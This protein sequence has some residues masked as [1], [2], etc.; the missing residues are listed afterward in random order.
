M[1]KLFR[2]AETSRDGAPVSL[3][4]TA[5]DEDFDSV[6]DLIESSEPSDNDTRETRD[7]LRRRRAA[8]HH[9]AAERGYG[10]DDQPALASSTEPS[11][12]DS[13]DTV[14][15][16]PTKR[17]KTKAARKKARKRAALDRRAKVAKMMSSF[18]SPPIAPTTSMPML[19]NEGEILPAHAASQPRSIDNENRLVIS[20]PSNSFVLCGG[21][22]ASTRT[23]A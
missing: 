8:M 11:E 3:L 20:H 17:M 15:E 7:A 14:E 1:E 5:G 18:A 13:A 2:E 21:V 22:G 4:A 16:P 12:S 10:T 23:L 19:I 9:Q 6:P